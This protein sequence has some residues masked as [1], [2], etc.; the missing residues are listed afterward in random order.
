[1]TIA[2]WGYG[3]ASVPYYLRGVYLV[4]T[5][6]LYGPISSATPFGIAIGAFT[7]CVLLPV[8]LAFLTWLLI[9][10]ARVYQAFSRALT[11]G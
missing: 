1:M 10:L 2:M 7:A 9:L 6:A 11:A 3:A 8:K 4:W 5:T